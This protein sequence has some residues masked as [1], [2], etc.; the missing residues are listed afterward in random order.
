MLLA[1]NFYL[2]ALINRER[3]RERERKG[4]LGKCHLVMKQPGKKKASKETLNLFPR[5][6]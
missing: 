4:Q 6:I 1:S 3:E 2:M 5:S